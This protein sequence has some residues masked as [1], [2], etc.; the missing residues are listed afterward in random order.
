LPAVN[1]QIDTRSPA[2]DMPF[3]YPEPRAALTSAAVTS[4]HGSIAGLLVAG[5]VAGACAASVAAAGPAPIAGVR[6]SEPRHA[7]AVAAINPAVSSRTSGRRA[8]PQ[9]VMFITLRPMV[10]TRSCDADDAPDH[11]R[12]SS[13]DGRTKG[14]IVVDP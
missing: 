11:Q 12:R 1:R 3:P 14:L 7:A 5:A 9:D 13:P 8:A 6:S 2:V 4:V 10:A